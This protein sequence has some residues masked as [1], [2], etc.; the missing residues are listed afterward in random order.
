LR[1][2]LEAAFP[3][4]E[5]RVVGEKDRYV[6]L[7]TFIG[8]LCVSVVWVNEGRAGRTIRRGDVQEQWNAT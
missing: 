5:I 2:H 3:N 4:G 6:A 7:G 8:S 1:Q